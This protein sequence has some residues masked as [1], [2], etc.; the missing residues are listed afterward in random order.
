[1]D[2]LAIVRSVHHDAAPIHETGYQLI[3]T[4][5]LCRPG[6]EHPHFGSVVARLS[7]RDR[8]VPSF[9]VIPGPIET[10][11]V[12]ISRGQT[13]GWLG[14]AYEPR[15]VGHTQLL[16]REDSTT[17][18][19]YGRTPFGQNCLLALRLIESGVRVVTVNM[20]ETVFNRVTWDCHGHA[21]FST[22]DDYARELLPNFDQ[23]FSALIDDLHEC[24]RL[25]TTL[26][27]AAGEFGRTPY[28]NASGGR[29]HWPG[30]WSVVLAGGGTRGGQ[31]VGATDAMAGA[32]VDRPVTPTDIVAAIFRSLRID[33]KAY[34]SQPDRDPHRLVEDGA[35]IQ[36]LFG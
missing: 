20:F 16:E 9:V 10:T 5:R 14:T 19:A 11:G 25:E 7:N 23:A 17:R 28:L 8:D 15:H 12:D 33:G 27:I 29:D 21:P 35:A 22:L 4:G 36:E 30:A 2:R 26:V 32:P 24:G 3:Q 31:V 34:L 13:A 18:D 1:M 6:V